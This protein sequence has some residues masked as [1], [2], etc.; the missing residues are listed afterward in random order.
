MLDY[1]DVSLVKSYFNIQDMNYLIG[2]LGSF[3]MLVMF[4]LSSISFIQKIF[5]I[6]LLY[7]ISPISIATIPLDESNRFKVWKDMMIGSS[8]PKSTKVHRFVIP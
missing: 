7:L 4:M 8:T 1:K 6:I 3:V 2:I 5:D